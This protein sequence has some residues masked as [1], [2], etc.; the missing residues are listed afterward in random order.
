M[1]VI[2]TQSTSASLYSILTYQIK[3]PLP[4]PGYYIFKN[5]PTPLPPV[6]SNPPPTPRLLSVEEFFTPPPTPR[7][8]QPPFLLDTQEYLFSIKI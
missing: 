6:Y 4:H 7:L 3:F 8:F 1:L 5:L 2:A